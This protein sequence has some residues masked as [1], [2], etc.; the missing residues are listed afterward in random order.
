MSPRTRA[1]AAL[2]L[3]LA[4][5]CALTPSPSAP[6]VPVGPGPVE[7]LEAVGIAWRPTRLDLPAGVPPTVIV[8]NRD[9]GIPHGLDIRDELGAVVFHGEVVTGPAITRYLLPG[10]VPGAYRFMCPVHPTMAGDLFVR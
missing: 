6:L 2:M 10:L 8:E 3:L 1:I 7:E 4:A 9:Q 5:G